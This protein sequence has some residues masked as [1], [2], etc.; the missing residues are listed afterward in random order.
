VT[1]ITS[2][3]TDGSLLQRWRYALVLATGAMLRRPA[4]RRAVAALRET[5]EN[6]A[7]VRAL[8]HRYRESDPGFASDLYAAADRHEREHEAVVSGR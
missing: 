1:T 6:L 4:S 8:A 2:F 7:A 3:L 5:A